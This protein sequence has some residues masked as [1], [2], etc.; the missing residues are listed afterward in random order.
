MSNIIPFRTRE[1]I[2][3][4]RRERENKELMNYL[5]AEE[6]FFKFLDEHFKET[7]NKED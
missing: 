4:D 5:K 7:G 1:Q 3:K 6:D 2:E